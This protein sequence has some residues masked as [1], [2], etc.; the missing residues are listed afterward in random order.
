MSFLA[1][2]GK[3]FRDAGLGDIMIESGLVAQGS[4]NT[5]M[6]GHHYNRAMRAHKIMCEALR[7]LQCE[8]S[9]DTLTDEYD[10]LVADE[11]IQQMHN[12]Y[13]SD[14]FKE[15]IELEQFAK[16]EN[17]FQR[18]VDE[19]SERSKTYAFWKSYISIVETLL[20]VI[21]DTR[22]GDWNLHLAGIRS[23]LPWVCLFVCFVFGF[24]LF[25]FLFCFFFCL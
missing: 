7:R 12:S 4:L 13:P 20:L 11:L 21:R 16:L 22:E 24:V 19:G 9:V 15:V 23:M 25:L 3:R 18:F 1:T 5:V 17:S 14:S 10:K 2:I 6:K 8:S